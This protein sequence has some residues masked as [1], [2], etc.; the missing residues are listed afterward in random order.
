M[1]RPPSDYA[2]HMVAFDA[3]KSGRVSQ[4]LPRQMRAYR[5]QIAAHMA[6]VNF[7]RPASIS[8]SHLDQAMQPFSTYTKEVEQPAYIPTSSILRKDVAFVRLDGVRMQRNPEA[9]KSGIDAWGARDGGMPSESKRSMAGVYANYQEPDEHEALNKH[10]WRKH[11]AGFQQAKRAANPGQ[12]LHSIRQAYIEKSR[13][14][15]E[16]LQSEFAKNK[17]PSPAGFTDDKLKTLANSLSVDFYWLRDGKT[18]FHNR[19]TLP[20]WP[21]LVAAL[22]DLRE[23]Q[24]DQG[25]DV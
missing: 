23:S 2:L 15:M 1:R 25:L 13:E 8:L 9:T 24:T 3:F 19:K 17:R 21:C 4:T 12:S 11:E 20:A 7:K 5:L 10:D 18:E 6:G 14:N 16:L 22:T